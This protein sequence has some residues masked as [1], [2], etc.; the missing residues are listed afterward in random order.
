LRKLL[1]GR[2]LRSQAL[3]KLEELIVASD[4]LKDL[5]KLLKQGLIS[6]PGFKNLFEDLFCS[7]KCFLPPV[8]LVHHIYFRNLVTNALNRMHLG[9]I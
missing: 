5:V 1:I 6:D 9:F 4:F 7:R 2:V 8:T 3:S